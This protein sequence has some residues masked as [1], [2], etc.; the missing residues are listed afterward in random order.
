MDIS[1]IVKVFIR[2]RKLLV[3]IGKFSRVETFSNEEEEI[4]I[5]G[6][7]KFLYNIN[8]YVKVLLFRLNSG[9]TDLFKAFFQNCQ[10]F[11]QLIGFL[12]V[13]DL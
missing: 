10:E 8:F 12:L 9:S 13:E 5:K 2:S 6:W 4:W 3:S 7:I 1:L 11:S